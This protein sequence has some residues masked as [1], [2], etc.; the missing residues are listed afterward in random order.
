MEG[1]AVCSKILR[2]DGKKVYSYHETGNGYDTIGS[3]VTKTK[4]KDGA[5]NHAC[6]EC[7]QKAKHDVCPPLSDNHPPPPTHENSIVR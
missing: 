4:R 5:L 7:Y 6:Y 1:C 2:K 3:Y